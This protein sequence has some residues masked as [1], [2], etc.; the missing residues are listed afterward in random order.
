[1]GIHNQTLYQLN[2]VEYMAG[3]NHNTYQ[4]T[5]PAYNL[6]TCN[7]GSTPPPNT[8]ASGTYN[9][10]DPNTSDTMDLGWALHP[11][12]GNGPYIYLV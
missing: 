7:F 11:Q 4:P 1:L 9:I 6:W 8:L 3:A 10:K 2:G 5:D 12:W